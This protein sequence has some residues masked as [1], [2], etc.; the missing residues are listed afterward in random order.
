[1]TR[2]RR[3]CIWIPPKMMTSVVNSPEGRSIIVNVRQGQGVVLCLVG[4]CVTVSPNPSSPSDRQRNLSKRGWRAHLNLDKMTQ[5]SV[6]QEETTQ[7]LIL[8]GWT[9]FSDLNA[10]RLQRSPYFFP[11]YIFVKTNHI[12]F[13]SLKINGWHIND[14]H[15]CKNDFHQYHF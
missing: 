10:E 15:C 14:H 9:F 5:N 8:I 12:V 13:E 6:G 4:H 1:M 7:R 11:G 2:G 3:N